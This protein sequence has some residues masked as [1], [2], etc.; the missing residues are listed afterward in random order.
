MAWVCDPVRQRDGEDAAAFQGAATSPQ[1]T[2]P[3]ALSATGSR[4]LSIGPAEELVP[5][6][7]KSPF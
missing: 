7:E 1:N 6:L 3:P 4:S 2:R 5:Y